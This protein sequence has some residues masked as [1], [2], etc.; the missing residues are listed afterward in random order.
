MQGFTDAVSRGL[1]VGAG[2]TGAA[3][4]PPGVPPALADQILQL[5]HQAFAQAFVAAMRPT[6]VVPIVLI[7]L[8]A[9]SC[10]AVR[11]PSGQAE[12]VSEEERAVA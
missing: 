2:E 3:A 7:V 8:A 4:V 10:V 1:E 5:A 6:L 11:R 12:P 9:I